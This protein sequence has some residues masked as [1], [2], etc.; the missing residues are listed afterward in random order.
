[1][2]ITFSTDSKE[3]INNS[4]QN[5]VLKLYKKRKNKESIANR[6]TKI[7]EK[8]IISN[9][10]VYEKVQSSSS[11]GNMSFEFFYL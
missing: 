7:V 8:P 10:N 5:Y 1:M 6:T 2:F 11:S 4:I 3:I 9:K